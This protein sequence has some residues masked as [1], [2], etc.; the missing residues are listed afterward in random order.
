MNATTSGQARFQN[1]RVEDYY[2]SSTPEIPN[3]LLLPL[4]VYRQVIS[5]S[6]LA[7][8]FEKV[9][10]SN[11]WEPAWR[12][13]IYPFAHYHSTAHEVIGAYRGH[14]TV[15]FGH[16]GGVTLELRAGDAVAIPAGT[17]HQCLE[18][19]PDF[20]AVGAYPEGQEPDIMHADAATIQDARIRIDQVPL[21]ESDPIFGADG[22]L[23]ELW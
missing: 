10:A 14:A 17:G 2:L 3:N 18:S 22:P 8:E 20:H 12:Y 4:V 6:D 15:L 11:G 1:M 21:P 9:F 16:T 13:G 5:S 23:P 7:E 19:S